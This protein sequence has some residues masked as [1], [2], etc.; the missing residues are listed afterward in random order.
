ME[1]IE[2]MNAIIKDEIAAPCGLKYVDLFGKVTINGQATP[3]ST[4]DGI[5]FTADSYRVEYWLL[6]DA[7]RHQIAVTGKP[8]Q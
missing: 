8:C 7:L 5:H 4:T 3:G 1:T 6:D 2:Q